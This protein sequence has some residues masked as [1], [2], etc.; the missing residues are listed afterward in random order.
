MHSRDSMISVGIDIGTTTTQVVFSE[1][2]LVPVARPGQIPRM[3]ISDRKILYESDIVLTPLLDATRIDAEAVAALVRSEYVKAAIQ[4]D[5]VKTGAAIVTGE[6]ARKENAESVLSAIADLAGDFVVTVAGPNVEGLIAGRGSGAATWSRRN[7]STIASLDI[8]GGS[9]NAAVFR[10]GV[11]VASAAM[12]FGGRVLEFGGDVFKSATAAGKAI[13][14]AAGVMLEPGDKPDL[15]AVRRIA[16]TEASLVLDLIEG[17][18]SPLADR[19][20]QTEPLPG[21]HAVRNVSFSGGVGYYYYNPLTVRSLSDATIHGD[22]GPLLAD[23]MRRMERL[24]SFSIVQPEE[25]RR[26]TV[27]GASS[28]TMVLSGSTI[29]ADGAILPLR[30]VPVLKPQTPTAAMPFSAASLESA[31]RRWDLDPATDRYAFDLLL[32]DGM[33]YAA[34]TGIAEELASFA[35]RLP[36]GT[37]LIALTRH[38]YAQVLG[39]TIKGMDP[40]RPLLI[41]DQVGLDEGDFID[42]G[43]PLLDGRVVPLVVKT[44]IFYH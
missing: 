5:T 14:H 41:I 26:A 10:L 15:Q 30:N 39:M 7:F 3:D 11:P 24:S 44:L 35:A 40:D 28:Q 25:T 2:S 12:N 32:Q 42:I 31:V 19:L 38:D 27:L 36:V 37:P 9:A 23:S 16:D 20:Y 17:T 8:G 18:R 6:T 4:P 33:D 13:M 21:N 29:W 43:V 34:L 1:L 22:I